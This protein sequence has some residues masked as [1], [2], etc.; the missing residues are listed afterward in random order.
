MGMCAEDP[1][2]G[3]RQMIVPLRGRG[4]K[5]KASS[6]NPDVLFHFTQMSLGLILCPAQSGTQHSAGVIPSI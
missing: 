2:R 1:I 5:K 4:G 3:G 6:K